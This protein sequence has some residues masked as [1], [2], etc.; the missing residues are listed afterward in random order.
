MGL[1][2][3][4]G[5][6][7][8]SHL[9]FF[10]VWSSFLLGKHKEVKLLYV[11]TLFFFTFHVK[12]SKPNFWLSLR[13]FVFLDHAIFMSNGLWGAQIK[14]S[15]DCSIRLFHRASWCA[16]REKTLLVGVREFIRRTEFFSPIFIMC[17]MR[18]HPWKNLKLNGGIGFLQAIQKI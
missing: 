18:E 5:L 1:I 4:H 8:P 17:C 9:I 16:L 12:S 14:T 3:I 10:I 11:T 2:V 13:N 15:L 7:F 6:W